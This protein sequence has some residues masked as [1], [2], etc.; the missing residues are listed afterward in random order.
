VAR[1]QTGKTI[2]FDDLTPAKTVEGKADFDLVTPDADGI[3]VTV[4]V[5]FG[6]SADGDATLK[7]YHSADGGTTVDSVA[8]SSLAVT[9]SVAAGTTVIH[10]KLV[11]G[12]PW[13]RVAVLNGNTAVEDITI[14]GK[15]A[16]VF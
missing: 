16:L 4:S 14:S 13:L 10:S 5:A 8:D 11:R 3:L 12:Y 6:G 2:G 15:Y 9:Y 7:F 1:W